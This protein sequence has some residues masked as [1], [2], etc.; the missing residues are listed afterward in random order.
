MDRKHTLAR[1]C[2]IH[3]SHDLASVGQHDLRIKALNKGY[4]YLPSM[5]SVSDTHATLLLNIYMHTFKE[6]TEQVSLLRFMVS[7]SLC[8]HTY[9]CEYTFIHNTEQFICLYSLQWSLIAE[10]EL[11]FRISLVKTLRLCLRLN[12]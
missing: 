5:R 1:R 11:A 3:E 2:L 7:L 9:I 4:I 12:V 8:V 6:L 10:A